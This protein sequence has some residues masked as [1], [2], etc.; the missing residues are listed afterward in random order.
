MQLVATALLALPLAGMIPG[1]IPANYEGAFV[2]LAIPPDDIASGKRG[3]KA[4]S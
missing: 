2:Y 1:A 3:F 4:D